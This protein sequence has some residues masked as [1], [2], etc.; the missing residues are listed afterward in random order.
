MMVKA[1]GRWIGRIDGT[2]QGTFVLEVQQHDAALT[3][4]LNLSD[5]RFGTAVFDA[6][7]TVDK[8]NVTLL[9]PRHAAAPLHGFNGLPTRFQFY[10]LAPFLYRVLTFTSATESPTPR[11]ICNSHTWSVGIAGGCGNMGGF[12]SES[13]IWRKEGDISA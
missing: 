11:H 1:G 4:E 9:L 8:E 2:N 6:V 5:S 10:A 13:I 3:G 7:G 12:P